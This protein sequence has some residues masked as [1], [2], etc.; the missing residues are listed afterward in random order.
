M[1]LSP[2]YK[3]IGGGIAGLIIAEA[4]RFGFQPD[5]PTANA[6]SVVITALLGYGVGHL[7]VYFFP[8]NQPKI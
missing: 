5:G 4:A 3:A 8:K 2:I 1:D 7:I 6:L